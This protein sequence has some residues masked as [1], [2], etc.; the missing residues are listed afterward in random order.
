GPRDDLR[1]LDRRP[2]GLFREG[3]EFVVEDSAPEGFCPWAWADIHGDLLAVLGAS[4]PRCATSH[5]R[6]SRCGDGRHPVIFRI[7]PMEAC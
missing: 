1:L 2:C 7:E 6:E 3:D 5:V 4:A